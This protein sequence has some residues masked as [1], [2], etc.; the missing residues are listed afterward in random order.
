ME[1]RKNNLRIT[2]ILSRA[3]DL[4]VDNFL[5]FLKA[6][7]IFMAPAIILPLIL[8]YTVFATAFISSS[9]LYSYSY[10]DS[11]LDRV[12][13]G[14]GIGTVVTIMVLSL[15]LGIISLFGSLVIIKISDDANKGNEVSWRSATRYVWDRKWRALG[16]NILVWLMIMAL[17]IALIILFIILTIITLGLGLIILIPLFFGILLIITPS[18][19][20]FNSTFLINDLSVTDSIRETFLLFRKGYFWSTIGRIAAISGILFIVVIISAILDFIPFLGTIIMSLGSCAAS[21]YM[22]AYISIFVLDRNQPNV[23]NF[24]GN[25]NSDNGFIDP[26]I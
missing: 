17:M 8:F 25:D 24:G 23:D 6:I 12:F 5:E 13:T 22:S 16:L 11:A 14:L 26:I 4:C 21:V 7:G 9:F 19:T 10:T 1:I 3:F 20:L 18:M 2:E 15:I